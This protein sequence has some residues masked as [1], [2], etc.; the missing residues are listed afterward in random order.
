MA[1][2][3]YKTS[4]WLALRDGSVSSRYQTPSALVL[5]KVQRLGLSLKPR[6][7]DTLAHTSW[8]CIWEEIQLGHWWKSQKAVRSIHWTL[9]GGS[10]VWKEWGGYALTIAAFLLSWPSQTTE[11]ELLD[12]SSLC[13]GNLSRLTAFIS[14]SR[15]FGLVAVVYV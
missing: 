15:L 13:E 10:F 2:P 1:T 3:S 6:A 12:V 5:F 7:W 4:I 9:A 11:M 14:K 8:H